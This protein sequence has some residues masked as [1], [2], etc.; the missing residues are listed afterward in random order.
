MKKIKHLLTTSLFLSVLV[1]SSCAQ[2]INEKIGAIVPEPLEDFQSNRITFNGNYTENKSFGK[3]LLHYDTSIQ[4]NRN[5][6]KITIKGTPSKDIHTL[7]INAWSD[8]Q[9]DNY[10]GVLYSTLAQDLQ[11][12]NFFEITTKV[13]PF[14]TL[15]SERS[16][17]YHLESSETDFFIKDFDI[18]FEVVDS[19]IVLEKNEWDNCEKI[20]RFS[21]LCSQEQKIY[22][23][24]YINLDLSFDSPTEIKN[25]YYNFAY[26]GNEWKGTK[27]TQIKDISQGYNHFTISIPVEEDFCPPGSEY[28]PKDMRMSLWYWIREEM[29]GTRVNPQDSI[30]LTNF[31]AEVSISWEPRWKTWELSKNSQ[32]LFIYDD[33]AFTNIT[34]NTNFWEATNISRYSVNSIHIE[35]GVTQIPGNAFWGCYNVTSINLPS[36]LTSIGYDAFNGNQCNE[37]RIPASVTYIG[38]LAFKTSYADPGRRLRVIIDCPHDD[39]TQRDFEEDAFGYT[40][41]DITYNDNYKFSNGSI[42]YNS[43]KDI[44]T[45]S[46]EGKIEKFTTQDNFSQSIATPDGSLSPSDFSNIRTIIIEE[47]I[48]EI[49]DNAFYGCWNVESISLPGTL[50]SIGKNAFS[51][52]NCSEITIPSSVTHIGADAFTSYSSTPPVIILKWNHDD[53]TTRTFDSEAFYGTYRVRYEDDYILKPGYDYYYKISGAADEILTIT[54]NG[55]IEYNAFSSFSSNYPQIS[56]IIIKDGITEIGSY[57]FSDCHN[58]TSITLPDTLETIRYNAFYNNS[59]SEIT[60]PSSVKNI[61]HTAFYGYQYPSPLEITLDWNHNDTVTR[62]FDLSAFSNTKKV[63]YKDGYSIF[64]TKYAVKV[65]NTDTLYVYANGVIESSAFTSFSDQFPDITKIII[66]DGITEIEMY[67]FDFCTNVTSIELPDSLVTIGQS[68]FYDNNCQY[69]TIPSSV[70]RIYSYAFGPDTNMYLEVTL[71]WDSTDTTPRTINFDAFKEDFT[72]PKSVKFNDNTPW[73]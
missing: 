59:C 36:T 15:Y 19:G 52:N 38:S 17:T 54:G 24:N 56:S 61:E 65:E 47:G 42:Y 5:A 57:A 18:S 41:A 46:G 22:F 35:E 67:A 62:T 12:D 14:T 68:A 51:R 32:T 28:S 37:I 11:A 48:T 72:S 13:Q 71:D 2:F 30:E 20:I 23:G 29:S 9:S 7:S 1:F 40:T 58:V 26:E 21:E 3:T 69:I 63:E 34:D 16:Y 8:S 44:L 6:I 33:L 55:E 27:E 66:E 73:P 39:T 25:L 43:D 53:T 50:V 10:R 45:I 49:D 70:T 4:W 60:I 31:N 64:N